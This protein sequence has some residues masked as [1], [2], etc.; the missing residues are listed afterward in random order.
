MLRI[1]Y[2]RDFDG[3]ASAAILAEALESS[4]REKR[5]TWAGVN[6]DDR[7]CGFV[8]GLIREGEAAG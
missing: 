2:H 7:F 3:M 8:D 1:Y 5:T 6:F 4:G